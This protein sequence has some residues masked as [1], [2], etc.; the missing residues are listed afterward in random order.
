MHAHI[1]RMLTWHRRDYARST[2]FIL[3]TQPPFSVVAPDGYLAE[4]ASCQ[5]L[6]TLELG[7]NLT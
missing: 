5:V 4:G 7:R 6:Q 2:K 3:K 1:H